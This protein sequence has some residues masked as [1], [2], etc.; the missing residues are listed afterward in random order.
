MAGKHETQNYETRPN[1]NHG[2]HGQLDAG[3]R[4]D[5][6]GAGGI[7]LAPQLAYWRQKLGGELPALDV[8]KDR[9]RRAQSPGLPDHRIPFRLA[10]DLIRLAEEFAKSECTT[11]FVVL[12]TAYKIL[13]LRL[14]GQSDVIV[15]AALPVA[16]D[17]TGS[18]PEDAGAIAALRTN[19]DGNPCFREAVRRVQATALEAQANRGVSLDRVVKELAIAGD[20]ATPSIF[21]AQFAIDVAPE[22]GGCSAAQ[23]GNARVCNTDVDLTLVAMTKENS[24]ASG[25]MAYAADVFD[26][27]T[28]RRYLDIYPRL[29]SAM[30]EQPDRPLKRHALVSAAEQERILFD[31]NPYA[32]PE[33][34]YRTMAEPFEQQ[35]A[36]T[37]EAVALIG[38]EG[39]MTYGQLN[40]RAN[41]LAHFLRNSGA[42]RFGFVAICMERSFSLMVALYAIAKSGAAYVPLDSELPDARIAFML[43]DTAPRLVLVD[44][45]STAKVSPGPWQIICMDDDG[46]RWAALPSEN[47]PCDGPTNHAVHLLYTSGSTGRPKAVAYPVN[48]AIAEIFWLQ[49]FYPFG[50]GDANAFKTSHGFDVS[51]WEIF[52]TLYF[53]ATLV[54]CRP[55]AHRDP[56]YLADVIEKYGVT[57][58]FLG[59]SMLQVFLDQLPE[60]RCR[61]LRWVICGGEPMTPRLRDTFYARLG[62]KLINGFGPTEA[63][64]VTDMIIP[65]DEGSPVVP[66]GRPAANFRLYVLDEELNVAPIGVPGEAYIAGEIG[67]AQCYHRRPELTAERFLPDPFGPPGGRMY[68][69]GDICRYRDNGVLEHL[70]RSGRQ[71]K[72]RGLRVELA[73]IE[74]VLCEHPSVATCFAM[75]TNDEAGQRILAFVVPR[76]DAALSPSELTDHAGRLL[77]RFMVPSAIVGMARIPTNVNG[78]VD[79]EALLQC[80]RDA[81]TVRPALAG[82][83]PLEQEIAEVWTNLVGRPPG[84]VNEDFLESGG[85]S[86][87]MLRL[88][89]QLS[90]LTGLELEITE[91]IDTRTVRALA[92]GLQKARQR[93]GKQDDREYD[94]VRRL[95]QSRTAANHPA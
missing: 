75:A 17:S 90:D 31:L 8:P 34:P 67:L 83:T 19:L 64:T 65:P 23:T 44:R 61:S 68:R 18:F 56:V 52:W 37:P 3:G 48:A 16:I 77:P 6:G 4:R 60:G 42:G 54:V 2:R 95:A 62:A 79:R 21:Q 30:L 74:A 22:D 38:D 87:L 80:W 82:A 91:F 11:L 33:H 84:S 40:R 93:A 47:I 85:D 66:L 14:T 12:L 43:E 36:R 29:L 7:D 50:I 1:A 59:P 89:S 70:G 81:D 78:K 92:E 10:P 32:R 63:G 26:P 24:V 13:L 71:V 35:V 46:D 5:N 28:V 88:V 58:I 39:Q 51:I 73:E 27:A 41:R 72:L 49:R 25:F 45:A 55:G 76:N 86:L 57:W 94:P 20:A 69:T 9:P 15:G 53:G